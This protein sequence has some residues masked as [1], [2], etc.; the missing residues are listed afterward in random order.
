MQ[1]R[2]D[3]QILGRAGVEGGIGVTYGR[4]NSKGAVEKIILGVLLGVLSIFKILKSFVR[5][6][7][8]ACLGSHRPRKISPRG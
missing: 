7:F 1:D 4:E 8:E 3:S 5:A 6:G 2:L